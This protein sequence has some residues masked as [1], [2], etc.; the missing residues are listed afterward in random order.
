MAGVPEAFEGASPFIPSAAS[1][2]VHTPPDLAS[3]QRILERFTRALRVCG[4]VGEDRNAQ[5]IFL[6]LT[7]R[8]LDEPVSL[9]LKGVSSSGKSHTVESTLRFFPQDAYLEMTAM[10]ER[11]L[12]YMKDDFSHRSIVLFEAVALREQREK[13][14][15]NL[16]AY[17]VRSLLSEGRISYPVTQ[18]DKDGNFVTKTI[19]KNGP[20]NIILTT[21][22]TSLHGENET[23]LISLP[24][25]DTP[26][27]TA[28][29]FLQLAAGV[30][31]QVDLREWHQL[32]A[33]LEHAERRVVIPF[34]TF[35]ARS[36]PPVAVRLRRDFKSI[37]RL[38]ETHALV[39]QRSRPRDDAGRIIATEAD[40]LAVRELVSDLIADGVG[41]TVPETIRET[42]EAV[43]T[44]LEREPDGSGVAVRSVAAALD[45]DRSATSRRL[46]AARERGF[47][48]NEETRR[49]RPARYVIGEPMPDEMDLLPHTCTPDQLGPAGQPRV[50][51]SAAVHEGEELSYRQVQR[52]AGEEPET[53]EALAYL[54]LQRVVDELKQEAA[55][56][57]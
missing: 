30:S 42:V 3:D 45:L 21:T 26:A 16:T 10:S 20:T 37:L 32:Q 41:A 46:Q 51:S 33:W 40:Y 49:G 48:V 6:A 2:Q 19:V 24:T 5:L 12:V 39:H 47:V 14:E 9:A 1:A 18:R 27:Q 25:N 43:R 34:A 17:F 35:L 55:G 44:M 56:G 38:I 8:L 7:S 31:A 15:S 50:C 28:A 29:I 22:A 13:A 4:V 11:A 53:D 52:E 54:R 36:I 23:R 57:S